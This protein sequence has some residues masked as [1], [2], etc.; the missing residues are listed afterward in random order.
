MVQEPINDAE[1]SAARY[2][3]LWIEQEKLPYEDMMLPINAS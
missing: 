3:S 1:K 2:K